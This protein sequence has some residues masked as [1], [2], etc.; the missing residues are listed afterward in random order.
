M[1]KI[2]S[3]ENLKVYDNEC[4]RSVIIGDQVKLEHSGYTIGK[5]LSASSDIGKGRKNQEDSYIILEHPVNPDFKLIAVS[6]GVGGEKNGEIAS[7]ET[8]K[9][10]SLWFRSLDINCMHDMNEVR[11]SLRKRLSNILE[12]V[13]IISGAATLSAAIIGND[14][15][16]IAN[17][18][19]SRVYSYKEGILKQETR[20]DSEVQCL[21]EDEVIPSKE[22]MRF[23]FGSNVITQA[24]IQKMSPRDNYNVSFSVIP[25]DSYD[26]IYAFTDGVTDCLSKKELENIIK[27][28]KGTV[29][30]KIVKEALNNDSDLYEEIE[31]LPQKEKEVAY[32][33]MEFIDSDYHKN[34]PGGK[35]NTTAVEYR[36]K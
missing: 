7:N 30:E 35:D 19:D 13:N 34:I 11:R 3:I 20:D 36:K 4:L 2:K 32:E 9:K 12:D 14:E 33:L 17:I 26:R 23:H 15:T 18:G 29:S 16:L 8:I 24:I 1:K 21:Y 27:N 10:L 31:K 6:D 28:S 5:Q 22:L 25:N